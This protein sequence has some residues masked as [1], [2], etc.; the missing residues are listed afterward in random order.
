[1]TAWEFLRLLHKDCCFQTR[2]GKKVGR[3]STSELKRWFNNKAVIIDG[4]AARWDQE[5]VFPVQ[6]FVLF[7]NN[8][9]TL[10]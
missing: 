9:V 3:A 4:V 2:E 1:M 5:M 7:P 8:P 10:W 6:S